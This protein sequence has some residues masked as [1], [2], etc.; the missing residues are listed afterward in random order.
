MLK[1]ITEICL[2]RGSKSKNHIKSGAVL[3]WSST[4]AC[5]D[6]TEVE[7]YLP[8]PWAELTAKGVGGGRTR[9][10]KFFQ[11]SFLN[12]LCAEASA[13]IQQTRGKDDCSWRN[14]RAKEKTAGSPVETDISALG[15]EPW[16]QPVFIHHCMLQLTFGGGNKEIIAIKQSLTKGQR[17]KGLQISVTG[18]RHMVTKPT[19]HS[20]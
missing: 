11:L 10:R 5:T 4:V 8:F 14:R 18:F 7:A 19:N 16:K 13:C 2:H 17:D 15:T 20:A 6:Q 9:E 12:Q 3:L 1:Y